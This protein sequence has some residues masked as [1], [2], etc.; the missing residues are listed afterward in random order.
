MHGT[1]K[2]MLGYFNPTL[3]QIW[4]NPAIG[5]NFFNYIFTPT[6]ASAHI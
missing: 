2:K 6:F 1:L 3:R 4:T 5:L